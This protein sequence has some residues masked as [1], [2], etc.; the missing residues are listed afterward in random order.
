MVQTQGYRYLQFIRL[1]DLVHWKIDT[2]LDATTYEKLAGAFR[3]RLIDNFTPLDYDCVESI[4]ADEDVCTTYRG[5]IKF[6]AKD[7]EHTFVEGGEVSRKSHKQKL[8]AIAKQ[9]IARGKVRQTT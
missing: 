5:Y 6:L 3:Q 7:L 4:K 8:E 9:M 1:R 2:P